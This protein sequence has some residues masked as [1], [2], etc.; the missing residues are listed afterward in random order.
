VAGDRSATPF[1]SET[2]MDTAETW[3]DEPSN[4]GLGAGGDLA[5]DDF[6]STV[7]GDPEFQGLAEP[8]DIDVPDLSYLDESER[9]RF[10]FDSPPEAAAEVDPGLPDSAGTIDDI[11][12]SPTGVTGP[13]GAVAPDLVGAGDT[14]EPSPTDEFQVARSGDDMV[15]DIADSPTGVVDAEATTDAIEDEGTPLSTLPRE[16]VPLTADPSPATDRSAATGP[17]GSIRGDANGSCPAEYPIK[18]NSSSKIYHV[19]DVASYAGT[20]AEWCF[21][22]EE[23]AQ[24]AG[25]RPPGQRNRG[26]GGRNA[27]RRNR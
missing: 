2:G 25:Y 14:L 12:A 24:A 3:E 19:P 21:A 22:S 9:A 6:G 8:S 1:G 15:D 27:G 20:K 7:D 10:D 16:H 23:Q 13:E 4:E 17:G 26:A 11:G 5:A 18:G